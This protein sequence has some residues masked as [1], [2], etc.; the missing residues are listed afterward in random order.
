MS[1]W[2]AKCAVLVTVSEGLVVYH[3]SGKSHQNRTKVGGESTVAA[4]SHRC[5]RPVFPVSLQLGPWSCAKLY[6]AAK[7]KG[8]PALRNFPGQCLNAIA[9]GQHPEVVSG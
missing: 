9:N 8:C 7:L 1:K 3:D 6:R 4:S 2:F 5:R